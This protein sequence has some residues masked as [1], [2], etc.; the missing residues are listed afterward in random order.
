MDFWLRN[1]DDAEA[2]VA[3]CKRFKDNGDIDVRYAHY[4]VDG[5]SYLGVLSLVGHEVF[6]DP[7]FE[8]E[9]KEKEFL[10]GLKYVSGLL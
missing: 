4:V 5:C 2:L 7:F 10:E 8:T 1:S 3:Y 9:D 6:V